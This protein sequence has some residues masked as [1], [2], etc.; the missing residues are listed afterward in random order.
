MSK[1]KSNKTSDATETTKANKVGELFP[2]ASLEEYAEL[3]RDGD[4]DLHDKD[5]TRVL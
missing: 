5:K 3:N 1:D 2:S 4:E